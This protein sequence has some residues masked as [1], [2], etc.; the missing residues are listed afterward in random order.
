MTSTIS[1]TMTLTVNVARVVKARG[2]VLF[3]RVVMGLASTGQVITTYRRVNTSVGGTFYQGK[4]G[5]VSIDQVFDV[6]GGGVCVFFSLWDKWGLFR[7]FATSATT[8]VARYWGLREVRLLYVVTCLELRGG[9]GGGWW[10]AG[11]G[12]WEVGGGWWVVYQLYQQV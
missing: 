3:L 11:G 5:T 1:G 2:T 6:C 4:Y 10:E 12:R 8:G 9:G 7:V